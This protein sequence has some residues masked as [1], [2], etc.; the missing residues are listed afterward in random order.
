MAGN[1][2]LQFRTQLYRLGE[3]LTRQDLDSLTFLC[4]DIIPVAR[5]E[6]VRSPTD[7]WQAL[8]ERG[9]LS[10]HDLSYLTSLLNS[11]DKVNLLEGL[12]EHG[13]PTGSLQRDAEYKF[14]EDLL[15]VALSLTATEVKELSYLFQAWVQINPDKM[16]SATQ[17]FQVLLQR[18][19]ISPS[20]IEPLFE[21]LENIGRSDITKYIA[22]YL[23]RPQVHS[24]YVCMYVCTNV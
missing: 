12:Q 15:K 17:M 20:N 23:P 18:Q 22:C 19:I 2:D 3:Q 4:R 10:K 11:I 1:R 6:R 14:K 8:S 21:G 9:K 16:F 13:F 24:K 7:L 5:M